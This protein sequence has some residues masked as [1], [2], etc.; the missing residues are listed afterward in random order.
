[1]YLLIDE[2]GRRYLVKGESDVHTNYG[3][4]KAEQLIDENVGREIESHTG[5]RFFLIKPNTI[6]YIMKA[7][8]GPQTISLKDCGLIAAYTGIHSGSRVL[9]AGTGSGI[10]AMF[11]ANIVNPETLITYE[12]RED[13]AS[14]AKENFQKAGIKNIRL[15]MKNIYEGIDEVN[16]DLINLDLPEPWNVIEHAKKALKVGGFLVSYS[17]S[18]QQSK[19]FHDSLTGFEAETKECLVRDW[20]MKAVRPHSRMLA[21]TGFLTFARLIKKE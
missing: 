5:R 8:R 11:L 10:M 7:K 20:D 16:L 15:E 2:K 12:I 14:L 17:P 19:R 3:V 9:D 18:I 4:I 1:M 21:H 13:F 6:D